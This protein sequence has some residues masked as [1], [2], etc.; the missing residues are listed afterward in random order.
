MRNNWRPF[1]DKPLD[2]ADGS[3]LP[4]VYDQIVNSVSQGATVA[5]SIARGLSD[6]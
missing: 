6:V 3:T 2:S 4:D 1:L 5:K